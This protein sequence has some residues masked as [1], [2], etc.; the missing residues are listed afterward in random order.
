MINTAKTSTRCSTK[1]M[2]RII[3][4]MYE[5]HPPIVI[6]ELTGRSV[7]YIRCVAS[8]MGIKSGGRGK[9]FDD[10]WTPEEER[11]LDHCFG[12]SMTVPQL[13]RELGRTEAAIINKASRLG[14]GG[15]KLRRW[16]V[17]DDKTLLDMY[18]KHGCRVVAE[19][20]GR[21]IDAVKHRAKRLGVQSE[22]AKASHPWR[23]AE[24][25]RYDEVRRRYVRCTNKALGETNE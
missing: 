13:A 14:L 22:L 1:E 24:K 19:K 4:D 23:A 10:C 16:S 11:I 3:L 2:R 21:S 20:L 6:A 12:R 25:K 17:E 7:G 9:S 8:A 18:A 15:R 5:T